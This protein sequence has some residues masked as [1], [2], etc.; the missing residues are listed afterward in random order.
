MHSGAGR[1][2]V[3]PA[4]TNIFTAIQSDSRKAVNGLFVV[5]GTWEDETGGS[6]L[7]ISPRVNIRPSPRLQL[8]LGPS[9]SWNNDAWQYVSQS[10]AEDSTHYV[11]ADLEQRTVSLTARLNYTFSPELSLEFYA[12]PFISAGAYDGFKE[13]ADPKAGDFDDRFRSFADEEL[14]VCDGF[15]GVGAQAAGCEQDAGF[16]Y[17]FPDRDFNLKQFR[18]N[19]VLRWEYRPGSTLFLV[20]NSGLRDFRGD[21]S[22]DLS[23]DVDRL[24]GAP[25]RN[26]FLVKL[27]YWFGL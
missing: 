2:L 23:R 6:S 10:S 19:A 16:A 8:S 15:Y 4:E 24:F 9:I 3:T 11:F 1:P 5:R 27:S 18:S 14:R 25:G 22:F 12:Q 21:G 17:R 7:R 13:V 26:V 20:W